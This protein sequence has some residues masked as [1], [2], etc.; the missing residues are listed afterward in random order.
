M[1]QVSAQP[2]RPRHQPVRHARRI[3]KLMSQYFAAHGAT[4]EVLRR[5]FQEETKLKKQTFCNALVCAKAKEWIVGLGQQGVPNILNPNGCW[6]EALREPVHPAYQHRSNTLNGA[7]ELDESN[8]V[9]PNPTTVGPLW[10]NEDNNE[11]LA[12]ISE[13]LQH[14]DQKKN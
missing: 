10:N 8:F 5:R 9:S 2:V 3:V 14:I 13:A 1:N 6:M 12:L 4:T 11:D 7:A